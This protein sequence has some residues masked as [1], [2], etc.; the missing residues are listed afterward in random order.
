M[1]ARVRPLAAGYQE[2]W[3]V[4]VSISTSTIGAVVVVAVGGEIDVHTA[5]QVDDALEA[6]AGPGVAL[7]ADLSEVAFIDSTGLSVL[8]RALARA[9]DDDGSLALVAPTE[10][11][12]KVLRLTGLDAVLNVFDTLDA[13]VAGN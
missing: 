4:D 5:P 3:V 9:R 2:E 12:T 13:A 1:C 11:V 7:V 10:R 6:A 8:V